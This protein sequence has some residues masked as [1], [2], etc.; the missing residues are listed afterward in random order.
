MHEACTLHMYLL[1]HTL[2]EVN[3]FRARS[4]RDPVIVKPRV[5]FSWNH[6]IRRAACQVHQGGQDIG[7]PGKQI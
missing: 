1:L 3:Q 6:A 2:E 5:E 4:C 7:N